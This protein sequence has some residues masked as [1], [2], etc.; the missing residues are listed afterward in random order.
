LAAGEPGT[1]AVVAVGPYSPRTFTAP[2][3]VRNNTCAA[4]TEVCVYVWVLPY[5]NGPRSYPDGDSC[6]VPG[7]DPPVLGPGEVGIGGLYFGDPVVTSQPA[8][9][10]DARYEFEV[11]FVSERGPSHDACEFS[12]SLVCADEPAR[13]VFRR[14]SGTALVPIDVRM[15]ENRR[16]HP[17]LRG[18]VRNTERGIIEGPALVQALCFDGSG[19]PIAAAW[20]GSVEFAGPP[21]DDL[22]PG[23]LG[24]GDRAPFA[25]ARFPQVAG[26]AACPVY[27]VGVHGF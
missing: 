9:P 2:V 4:V 24:P 12:D 13:R 20:F 19:T 15:S 11:A 21:R 7:I 25:G 6:T 5:R 18:T 3:V 16:G 1:V 26:L 23:V 14:W 22:T 8:P 10:P 17:T 27:L